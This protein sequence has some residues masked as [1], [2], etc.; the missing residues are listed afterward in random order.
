MSFF[1]L[2]GAPCE[3]FGEWQLSLLVLIFGPIDENKG[4]QSSMYSA[5]KKRALFD[6]TIVD[7]DTANAKFI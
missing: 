2:R 1:V 7:K 3:G 5:S 6:N 4:S